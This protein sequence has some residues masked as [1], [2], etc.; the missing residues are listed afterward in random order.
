MSSS[1][2]MDAF[3]REARS[4]DEAAEETGAALRERLD[5]RIAAESAGVQS[6][7]G[8]LARLPNVLRFV[9]P[10]GLA[11]VGLL[12]WELRRGN[13]VESPA[14]GTTIGANSA[15]IVTV[16]PQ[17]PQQSEASPS[18]VTPTPERTIDVRDLPSTS[19]A[20]K[21]RSAQGQ[22]LGPAD[23]SLE[24]ETKLL[25]DARTARLAGAPERSLS[26]TNEHATRF[27]K[28]ALA[29]ERDAERISALCALGRRED[30]RLQIG[31]FEARWPSSSLLERV[32]ASCRGLP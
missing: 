6:A 9:A 3:L 8:A 10:V 18:Q 14:G 22:A 4:F 11:C 24:V 23:E 30:A 27:P 25:R 16:V 29:P 32:R 26:L 13:V 21:P 15:P 17:A 7:T 1:D 2:D 20:T 28:G 5:R 19:I 12:V 31:E